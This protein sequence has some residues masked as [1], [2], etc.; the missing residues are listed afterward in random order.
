MKV[1]ASTKTISKLNGLAVSKQYDHSLTF[2]ISQLYVS[3]NKTRALIKPNKGLPNCPQPAPNQSERRLI[4][5]TLA[6]PRKTSRKENKFGTGALLRKQEPDSI[7][8]CP[9]D[10]SL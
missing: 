1:A 6:S 2:N 8:V 4:I 9:Q 10:E 7:S 5:R 3:N